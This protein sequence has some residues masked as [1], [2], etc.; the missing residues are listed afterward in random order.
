MGE[1][2]LTRFGYSVVTAEDGQA[3]W[4]FLCAGANEIDLI[5]TDVIMPRLSGGELYER[6]RGTD[7]RTPFLFTTGYAVSE[8]DGG[9]MQADGVPM[10]PKPW[11]ADQLVR[12]V[13][14]ALDAQRS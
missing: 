13:R 1:R 2:I 9:S 6:V 7:C 8:I 14:G 11:T 10:L 5:V 3:A 4:D 12:G